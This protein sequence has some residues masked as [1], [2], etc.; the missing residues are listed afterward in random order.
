MNFA[1]TRCGSRHWPDVSRSCPLC[2]D[3]GEDIDRAVQ[4]PLTASEQAVKRF[5]ANGC[6]KYS[7]SHWWTQIDQQTNNDIAP[8]AM[9]ERLAQLHEEAR[10]DAWQDL[11]VPP[12]HQ[13]WA[14]V[15]A[16]AGFDLCK[17]LTPFRPSEC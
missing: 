13:A 5:V 10:R 17:H 8:D 9:A 11:E 16:L 6:K 7:A 15:C 12:S 2:N 4:H 1:C 3:T 14:D